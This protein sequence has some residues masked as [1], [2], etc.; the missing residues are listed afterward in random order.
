MGSHSLLQGI[1][2]AWEPGSP[3]LQA[4]SVPS[5]PSGKP[6]RKQK[7]QVCDHVFNCPVAHRTVLDQRFSL[8]SAWALGVLSGSV[9]V[10]IVITSVKRR[11][12]AFIRIK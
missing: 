10:C 6:Q 5:E 8:V 3:A 7:P 12:T 1:F 11:F 9:G 2:L 4:D